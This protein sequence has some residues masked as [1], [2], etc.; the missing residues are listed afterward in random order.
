MLYTDQM[1][2]S[3]EVPVKP[4]RIVSLVPS[5]TELLYTLGLE[6]EV[7]GLTKFCIHPPHWRRQ[8]TI[9]GGTKNFHLDKIRELQPDLI[10]GNK[11]ENYQEGIEALE[12]EFP[13]WMSDIFTIEDALQMMREVGRLTGR[14]DESGQLTA[15]I[16]D[17]FNQLKP[18][19]SIS[20]LYFIWQKPYMAVGGNTFIDEMLRRC[21]FENLLAGQARYPELSA[22]DIKA[23]DPSLILLSSEPFPFKEK[24]VAQ[25]Q[26]I[27]PGAKVMVVDGEMFSWYGS[28]LQEAV[29]YLQELQ[30]QVRSLFHL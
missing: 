28:R 16:T 26:E 25:F 5:Q 30:Q 15:A 19:L 14:E 12:K 9:I 1:Q 21:G 2:R 13:V 18:L 22:E 7:V 10:I 3:V 4:R 6:E 29:P 17:G 23:L 11:E 27:C 8:K 24:H 20:T